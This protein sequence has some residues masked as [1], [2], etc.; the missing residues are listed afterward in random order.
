MLTSFTERL[1][2][3]AAEAGAAILDIY[4]TDFGVSHKQDSSPLTAADQRSHTI[5]LTRLRE[6]SPRLPV[7]S[8]EGKAIPYNERREWEYFW[9]VDPLDGTKEFVKRNGEFTVNIALIRGDRPVIGM[10][11]VPVSGTFYF[12]AEGLGAY[13]LVNDGAVSRSLT[14]DAL[15][16]RSRRLPFHDMREAAQ[17]EASLVVI[18]SRSHGTAEGEAFINAM[19]Q[20]YN[21]VE[22]MSAGSSLKFCFVA[23]G[24][25]DLYP[26]FGPTMEWDTAAAQ[27]IVEEA[28]GVVVDLSG[29]R[30]RYNKES[31][32]NSNFF[33]SCS[34][35]LISKIKEGK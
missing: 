11:Y 1:F 35:E 13:K 21:N 6:L 12:A 22:I 8:E 9:L 15:R 7:L 5:L 30:L 19:K 33:A 17:R 20:R 18:A 3:V 16:G 10:V 34:A 23:E 2:A 4:D 32:L 26:R 14:F 31:L 28:G 27:C 25:A 29:N 24:A